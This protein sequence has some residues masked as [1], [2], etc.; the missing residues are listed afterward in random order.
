M[1]LWSRLPGLLAALTTLLLAACA[2]PRTG[3]LGGTLTGDIAWRGEVYL[4]GDVILDERSRL[5]IAPG[6]TVIFLP[7]LPGEDRLTEHPNFPGSELVVHGT[8]V[9]EGTP[10][11]PVTFRSADPAAGRGSWGGVNLV[12]SPE[13]RFRFCR[14]AQADSALHSRES[15]V[16]V[17]ESIFEENR[18]AIR[19]HSS[20]IR[21]ERNLLRRNGTAI[22]FHYGAPL[23]RGNDLR[24]NGKGIFV[25][26]FPRSYRIEGNNIVASGSYSV[27]L[28]EDVPDDVLMAGNHWGTTMPAAIEAS[29]FDGRR[30]EHLGR[31]LW[32]PAADRPLEEAG[33][34]WKP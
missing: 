19:F 18:V 28:G 33:P 11:A 5:T 30:E 29:F 15:R 7:P 31:V 21:I 14:F 20:D 22:R 2:V 26:S 27:A 32:A 8:V 34:S 1:R 25:T 6:T 9:A 4:R 3:P 24:E 17:E 16:T 10:R 23:I 12:G 13:A